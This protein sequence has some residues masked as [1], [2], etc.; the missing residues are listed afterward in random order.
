[1]KEIG[2]FSTLEKEYVGEEMF[3]RILV[4]M[5]VLVWIGSS[6]NIL[7]DSDRK[8]FF[9]EDGSYKI[10]HLSDVH[11]R[12]PD[13]ACRD[14]LMKE[15]PACQSGEAATK[16][17]ISRLIAE[18]QPDL[19]VHTGDVVDFDTYP[20]SDGMD[21]IYGLSIAANVPWAATLG[22][23]DD[24]SDLTRPEVMDYIMSLDGTLSQVNELGEGPN[25]PNESYGNFILEIYNTTESARP[26]FRTYHLDANTNDYSFNDEQVAWWEATAAQYAASAPAPAMA[27]F[28]IPTTEYTTALLTGAPMTGKV[29]ERPC[30]SKRNSGMFDAFVKDGSIK[31]TFVGHDHT[32]D[33][34][35]LYNGVQ[36][37]YEGS[38]GYQA[39]GHCNP[40]KDLC[41]DR[42]A[43]VTEISEF[44]A[45]VSSWKRTDDRTT[46]PH[47][48]HVID[49]QVLWAADGAISTNPTFQ[50]SQDE[51][52]SLPHIS[53]KTVG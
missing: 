12:I 25:D 46:S 10:L 44:G 39:Y 33:Y 5:S 52:D 14:I 9:K 49:K 51:Y 11:Y 21:V 7:E 23:H 32:N 50:M 16:D 15:K 18:E 35:A 26:S 29:R 19:V 43:R 1:M 8:L 22:N 3:F 37:C 24:D 48:T 45:V 42:R 41:V 40:K 17:F 28:H 6:R 31:A 27:F 34:C 13:T 2:Y 4:G 20:S 38:P 47:S 36:L 30:H 53:T